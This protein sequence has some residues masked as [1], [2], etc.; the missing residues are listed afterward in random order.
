MFES[1]TLNI[2]CMKRKKNK[3][4]TEVIAILLANVITSI[5]FGEGKEQNTVN[6]QSLQQQS[7]P[8]KGG[9]GN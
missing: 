9:N 2:I 4:D 1:P 7:A 8:R 6:S 3:I 5:Q